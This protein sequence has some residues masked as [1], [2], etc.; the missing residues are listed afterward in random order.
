M[1]RLPSARGSSA[2]PLSMFE[3]P[4]DYMNSLKQ[5]GE[6]GKGSESVATSKQSKRRSLLP[7]FSSS[8]K[9]SEEIDAIQEDASQ[10]SARASPEE[11][12]QDDRKAMPPPALKPPRTASR[13]GHVIPTRTSSHMRL[14]G[15][16]AAAKAAPSA[17]A[18]TASRD[19]NVIPA[20]TSSQHQGSTSSTSAAAT[21]GIK[22]TG[23]TRLP[24]SPGP[25]TSSQ[26]APGLSN[27]AA[28][29][30]PTAQ[31][32][33]SAS[34]AKP[35]VLNTSIPGSQGLPTPGSPTRS[36]TS[37][38]PRSRS[39]LPPPSKPAFNTY[40]QHYSPVK[41]AL[42]K[43]P[44]PTSKSLKQSVPVPED[45]PISFESAL[46]QI[47]LLQLSLLHQQ[48]LPTLAGYEASAKQ[49][50]GKMHAKLQKEYALIHEQ[51]Q[52]HRRKA[53]LNALECWCPDTALLAEHLSSLSR[54][55]SDLRAHTEPGSRYSE[56]VETFETWADRA[57]SILMDAQPG[58]AFVE[59]LPESWRATH[60]S[61]ALNMRSIQR[62]ISMLPPLPPRSD[63]E[64]PSSLEIM[65][66]DCVLLVDGMLKELEV[67]TKLQKEVLQR[68]KARID[69][70]INALMSS[71][72]E[73]RAHE[74]ENW[75][76]A[77][78]NA[79]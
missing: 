37:T 5:M 46:E 20:R 12:A 72:A 76:P 44:I 61:L 49:K 63:A 67:M 56:M 29:V 1:S 70:Q 41:S 15:S 57:E 59:A 60:T 7:Q 62:D 10:S 74:K 58:A 35:P 16:V 21:S 52:E 71:G 64:N 36:A 9:V 27:G 47:E 69:E 40:Q 79:N 45:E 33:A 14:P 3:A 75:Q 66:D 53:N 24:Q 26:R 55:I 13:E 73:N 43:P 18:R 65:I 68:G 11:K 51:E 42:P 38:A 32:R 22:R 77:W 6:A 19:G 78:L 30:I 54:V 34:I 39:G 25:R 2:R 48:A 17:H 50:L 31:K 28:N 4:T 23:S 8:R